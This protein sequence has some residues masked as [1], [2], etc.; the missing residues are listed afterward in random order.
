MS[1]IISIVG[2]KGGVGKSTSAIN[3]GAALN[4]LGRSSIVIDGNLTTPNIGI[5]LG[6]PVVPV[7]L[8]HVLAKKNHISEAM[9]L[10]PSG[11]QI[12]PGDISTEQLKNVDPLKLNKAMLDLEGLADYILID[13]AAGLGRE[14]LAAIKASDKVLIITNPEMPAVTDALKTI[15]IVQDMKKQ[16]L[17]IVLTRTRDDGWDMSTNEVEKMLEYPIL[18]VVPEDNNVRKAMVLKNPVMFSY[19]NSEASKGYKKLASKI[20]GVKYKEEV[21]EEESFW[22]KLKSVFRI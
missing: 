11:M 17:G 22:D 4:S 15:Q 5:Y 8:H 21:K 9:Y 2:G 6:I 7:N 16:V 20:S 1:K 14:A 10:H 19:P 12:I 13:A 3:L 18:G